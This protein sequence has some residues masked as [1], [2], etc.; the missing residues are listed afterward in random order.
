MLEIILTLSQEPCDAK[1]VTTL[2]RVTVCVL[3]VTMALLRIIRNLPTNLDY[4]LVVGATISRI[5]RVDAT[6]R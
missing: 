6:D 2:D 1:T 5:R 4:C 3:T